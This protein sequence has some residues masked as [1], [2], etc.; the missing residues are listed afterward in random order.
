MLRR[1][2]VDE[3][4]AWHASNRAPGLLLTGARQVGKTTAV[5]TFAHESGLD[6]AEVN[7]YENRDAVQLVSEARDTDDLLFRLSV[8]TRTRID[9]ENTLLFLDEIQECQDIVTWVKFLAERHGLRTVL[10]GSLLGIDAFVHVRS[11]PIGYL[12]T[13]EMFPLDFEEFCWAS[14]MPDDTLDHALEDVRTDEKVSEFLHDRLSRLF[15]RFLL[16][17]GMPAGVQA[18]VDTAQI[19]PVR[20]IHRGIFALYE[21]DIAKYVRDKTE[22]RKIKMVYEAIPGQL[23]APSKRFKYARLGKDLRFADMETAFDWLAAA[24][25]AICATRTRGVDFPLGLLEDRASLKLFM[26]DVGLLTSRFMGNVEVEVL[27]GRS[28]I[29][30]GSIYENYVAQELRAQGFTPRY[31]SS[32]SVG[33]VD[34]MVEDTDRGKAVPIEVKSGKDYK[35]HSALT[36]LLRNPDAPRRACVLCNR[37][38]SRSGGLLYLPVYLCGRIRHIEWLWE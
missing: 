17:G 37:N 10:S 26:N 34:F 14:G 12:Q 20:E 24:G 25:V 4:A 28:T 30:Y 13:I 31:Y 1:K 38:A 36:N 22:A 3:I 8:L 6:L 19:A 18:F 11:L 33:E 5:R 29:N 21:S 23:N 2:A 9:P 7:F 35:R 32:K 27:A 15:D 16:V